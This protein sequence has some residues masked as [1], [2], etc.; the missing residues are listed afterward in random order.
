[1]TRLSF[2]LLILSLSAAPGAWASGDHDHD[3][4]DHADHE[5]QA[6]GPHGGRLLEDGDIS[7]E[8]QQAE[9]DGNVTFQAWVS[10]HGAPVDDAELVFTLTRLDEAPQTLV[11]QRAGDSWRAD[12]RVG[13]PHSF[14][15]T[16]TLR[17][18]GET[19]TW[20]WAS[21]EGRVEI[22]AAMARQSGVSTAPAGAGQIERLARAYGT[23]VTPPDHSASARARFPGVVT[24]VQATVGD[25]VSQGDT[26]AVIESSDSLR[27]YRL[28]AP[29]DGV[30][31]SQTVSPG[32]VVA[33]APLFTLINDR[34]L[35]AELKLFPRQ[36]GEVRAGQTVHLRTGEHRVEGRIAHI[37]PG[38]AGA[39]YVI[40]RVP[41][42]NPD[43]RFAPGDM[44][45]ADI[46][47]EQE[48]VPLRV[49]NRA[50]QTVDARTGVF[51]QAGD[52]Y[53]WRPLDLGRR[54][55]R[56]TEVL[57]GLRAGVRYVVDNSYLI[58]ADLE[59]AGAAHEH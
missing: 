36:R 6:A 24:S 35:W 18:D 4:G 12:D 28:R 55:D 59:K 22:E 41:L 49:D 42:D 27:S 19:H 40:A 31:Q 13:T 52:S 54:D 50:L 56:Y 10:A 45:N 44:V 17:H 57:G 51:I 48:E 20:Q 47:V 5:A 21:H 14:D 26:L 1:M 25:R 23:L 16:A 32:A 11:L 34:R 46:V 15:I 7:L 30:V 37:T 9:E 43:G 39:P 53:E 58:K 3:H 38:A 33:D 2:I 8:V 29:I